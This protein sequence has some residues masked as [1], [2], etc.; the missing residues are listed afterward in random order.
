M[1]SILID[2]LAMVALGVLAL[3]F[4]MVFYFVGVFFFAAVQTAFGF[5][6]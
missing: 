6:A 5:G 1:R 3:Y 2:A 4:A